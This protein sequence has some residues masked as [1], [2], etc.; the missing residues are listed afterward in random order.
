MIM[1]PTPVLDLAALTAPAFPM[2]LQLTNGDAL[3]L[4]QR[5]REVPLKRWVCEAEWRGQR[6]F[7]KL[8]FGQGAKRYA[9]RDRHGVTALMHAKILTPSL[10][11]SESQHALEI[12]VFE[13]IP[14]SQTIE[15]VWSRL[16]D[17]QRFQLAQSLVAVL[18]QHH[19]AGILQTDLYLKNFLLADERIYTIDGD[20]IRTFSSL[21]ASHAEHNL[22]RLLS[23]MDVLDVQ[24]WLPQ[25]LAAYRASNTSHSNQSSPVQPRPNQQQTL[26]A[27]SLVFRTQAANA[28]ANKK[29]FRSCTDVE[30]IHH[31]HLF[32]AV[33]RSLGSEAYPKDVD[34]LMGQG[35][36]L[37]GGNTCTVVQ[38]SMAGQPVVIKRYNIKSLWHGLGR[39]WRK[40]RAAVTWS[41]AHRLRLLGIPTPM[42]LAL[43]EPRFFGL[44]GKAYFVSAYLEAPDVKQYFLST[45]SQ[46]QASQAMLAIAR[47]FLRLYLLKISHGDCKYSNIKLLDGQP[48][49]IDLDSMRQHRSQILAQKSHIRDLRRFMRNWKDDASL[50]NA[51]V[52]AFHQ[53][54]AE[55]VPL[56]D[57]A[58][59]LKSS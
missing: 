40:T 25:L 14:N 50:Y 55:H 38:A 17:E 52:V 57:A 41:N 10:L 26:W 48:W 24:A 37:K 3:V 1:E 39:S 32:Q 49:L 22:A 36:L 30:V 4:L 15:S 27:R 20:G 7:V 29:V 9:E 13:A 16:Q 19:Q 21:S 46:H 8:F 47:L 56:L 42:P 33:A 23:K 11:F 34:A 6:V 44:R 31:L 53:V 59:I 35:E 51:F 2:N 58:N 43:V 5:V 28:Y 18:A 45:P 12:L 54:Y